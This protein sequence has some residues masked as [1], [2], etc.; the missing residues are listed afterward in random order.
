[1]ID[2]RF[3]VAP[4]LDTTDRHARYFLRLFSE[5]ILLYTEMVTANALLHGDAERLLAHHPAE[6]PVA[7][8]LGGSDPASLGACAAMG[9]ASGF[10]E[11]NLNVGCPSDRV[12][13]G[14]F[15][16]CLMAEPALVAECVASMR[17]S[18]RLPVTVKSRIGIDDLDSYRFFRRFIDTVAQAGCGVFIVH[19]RKAWL[20]GLSPKQ[21]R[22]IPPLDYD[23]VYRLKQERPDLTVVINGG[24]RSVDA[25]LGHLERVDG[26]M[27]GR[28]VV[29]NP[30][31]LFE[32]ARRVFAH[33]RVFDDRESILSRYLDYVE[34][35]L[36]QGVPLSRLTPPL[37]GL[38]Q[39]VA[40][41]R[42]FKRYIA[43]QAHREGAGAGTIAEAARRAFSLKLA[44]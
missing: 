1:M 2:R 9:E 30:S 38:F 27:I 32:V 22:E 24:I 33:S 12:Q 35:C 41:T 28:E 43:E 4:M 15:G 5:D 26:V 20:K 23:T 40:G 21:N 8:Q 31:M 36:A 13:S 44:A 19:A 6:H 3:A 18:T 25:C 14:R 7:L 17:E 39:G 10:A 29:Q 34:A 16:A 42:A 37:L 11:V